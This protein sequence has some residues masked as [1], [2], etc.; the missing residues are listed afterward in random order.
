[1]DVFSKGI[2]MLPAHAGV[3]LSFEELG[4]FSTDV[5]RTRGGDPKKWMF[6]QKEL[7]CYPHTRG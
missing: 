1:M 3:I 2:E 7:K 4:K 6:F 5:T